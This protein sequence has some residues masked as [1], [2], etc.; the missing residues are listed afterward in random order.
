MKPFLQYGLALILA[1][2]M[3]GRG[4]AATSGEL[5]QQALYS[6]EIEGD[7]PAAITQYETIIGNPASDRTHVAQALYRGGMC[8]LRLKDEPSAV[9]ALSKLVTDF[10]AEAALV[11]KAQAVLEEICFFDPADLMPPN[12][13]MYLELGN[14]GD[15]IDMVLDML[16][17]VSLDDPFAALAM[18]VEGQEDSDMVAGILRN[19]T[20]QQEFRKIRSVALGALELREENPP[21]V[22]VINFGDNNML[23]GVLLTSIS[24]ATKPAGLVDGMQT[25]I[26]PGKGAIACDDKV[27]ILATSQE[28]L[29]WSIGQ[30]M[31]RSN[32]DSLARANPSF[33][34]LGRDVRRSNL[35]TLWANP[36][37]WMAQWHE[38][39]P[40]KEKVVAKINGKDWSADELGMANIDEL[41]L[42]ASLETN[43]FGLDGR[44]F[45]KDDIRNVAYEMFKTPPVDGKGLQGVPADAVGMLSFDLAGSDSAQA[46]GLR[47]LALDKM[48]LELPAQLFDSMGQITLFALPC[49]DPDADMTFRP[50]LLVSCT[51]TVPVVNL[52]R[53]MTAK[54]EH[55][56]L[57]VEPADNVVL[58]ALEQ[59]VI[60]AAKAALSGKHS[61]NR[62]GFLSA[63]LNQYAGSAEKLALVRPAGFG[64]K[65]VAAKVRSGLDEARADQLAELQKQLVALME[66]TLLSIHT[67]EAENALAFEV[68]LKDLP[69]MGTMAN[70]IQQ[71]GQLNAPP[72][73]EDSPPP[74]KD[75]SQASE[76]PKGKPGHIPYAPVVKA[77]EKYSLVEI[78]GKPYVRYLLKSD[79]KNLSLESIVITIERDDVVL[80]TLKPTK[81][82]DGDNGSPD[83]PWEILLPVS[84]ELFEGADLVHNQEPGT[85]ALSIWIPTTLMELRNDLNDI[86]QTLESLKEE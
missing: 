46:A 39:N 63:P 32:D 56:P 7:L 75:E 26:Y 60:D 12:T 77:A 37:V 68:R 11:A 9:A 66:P 71:I 42:T 29:A 61:V 53:S 38:R 2:A 73:D 76:K 1:M 13:L 5:L 67:Q 30:Y 74:A 23:H 28:Q 81:R 49:D 45:F 80:E 59:D 78:D 17:D 86:K 44:I 4:M 33:Q 84:E 47:Q 83:Y 22:A 52:L 15:K 34:A 85:L 40:G 65:G 8:Y 14:P 82:T 51:D 62:E 25:F 21:F 79:K 19:S 18:K 24:V 54:L 69:Q 6:E 72:K 31:H 57:I 3:A 27:V 48:G 41:V 43:A 70:L 58:V 64:R 20:L 50:G 36:D 55:W 10:A 16:K 35:A